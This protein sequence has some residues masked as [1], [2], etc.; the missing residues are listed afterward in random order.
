MDEQAKVIRRGEGVSLLVG[1]AL[2][3]SKVGRQTTDRLFLA[4]HEL[5]VGFGG[6]PPHLHERMDHVFYVLDGVVRFTAGQEEFRTGPGDVAF[7]PR[8]V[9]HGFGNA[10]EVP[11]RMLEF[12][13]PGGFDAYYAELAEA[14]PAGALIEPETVRSIMA[15]HDIRPI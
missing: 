15:R 7:V 2:I 3:T 13:L 8:G 1:A 9:A 5:P 11:A 10:G 4:E 14:F 6:P 12:N